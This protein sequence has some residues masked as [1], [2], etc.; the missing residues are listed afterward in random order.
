MLSAL[1]EFVLRTVESLGYVGVAFFVML[2]TVFPPIPSELVLALAGFVASRGEASLAGMIAAAT[3]GSL[4]GAWMLYAAAALFGPGP[5]RALVRRYGRWLRITERDLDLAERWFYRWSTLA[6]LLCRCIPLARSLIS[7]PA[8]Y[9]RMRLLPFTIYTA[10]GSL[11][12]NAVFVT[13]GFLLGERWETVLE[14]ADYLEW[15]TIAAML[16]GLAYLAARLARR[17]LA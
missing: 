12:W 8:G 7:V 1:T 2:E 6:V 4:A 13:A 3:A 5:L 16:A 14:Y 17:R 10:M 15:A 9:S 11:V